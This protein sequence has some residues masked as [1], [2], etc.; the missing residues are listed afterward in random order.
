MCQRTARQ[1]KSKLK[2]ASH[3]SALLPGDPRETCREE[4]HANLLQTHLPLPPLYPPSI[5][6]ESLAESQFSNYSNC[7]FHPVMLTSA[8]SLNPAFAA[9]NCERSELQHLSAQADGQVQLQS[10]ARAQPNAIAAAPLTSGRPPLPIAC[11]DC[12]A[13]VRENTWELRK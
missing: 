12:P 13:K 5:Y 10:K 3:T 9:V 2:P 8:Q 11:N 1:R 4:H 6:V 7:I